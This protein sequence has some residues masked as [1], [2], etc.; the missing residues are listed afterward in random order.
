MTWFARAATALLTLVATATVLTP[1]GA[2]AAAPGGRTFLKATTIRSDDGKVLPATIYRLPNGY[3]ETVVEP[4]AFQK[5]LAAAAESSDPCGYVC[6]GKNPATY[7]V[8]GRDGH[9][10]LCGSD[11]FSP[12]TLNGGYAVVELRYSP[13]CRTA[14]TRGCCYTVFS[15]FSYYSNGVQRDWVYAEARNSGKSVYTVMLNDAYL[16]Y[17]A[18]YDSQI[19][20][21]PEW[22][23]TGK[24]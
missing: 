14:W 10:Y 22:A 5:A 8:L 15:G 4:A 23:C 6:D 16:Q 1:G 13:R 21:T 20:G 11:A 19:G 2:T 3:T 12:R 7:P 17:K 24:Y 9:T 18:C